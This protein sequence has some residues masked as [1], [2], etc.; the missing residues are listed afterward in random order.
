MLDVADRLAIF[1]LVALHGHLVDAGR[2]DDLGQVFAPDVVYDL[3]D[4]GSGTS[5]GLDQ[6]KDM[7]LQMGD[8]NPVGHHV[9]NTIIEDVLDDGHVR[10][11]SKAIGIRADG[12][13]GSLTYVDVV[14]RTDAGWRITHRKIIL[15]RKPLG[16]G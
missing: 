4:F 3:T 11:R 1:E 14:A 15:H 8:R 9:T 16:A 6:L 5:V 2:L 7:A 10:V 13:A 12:S